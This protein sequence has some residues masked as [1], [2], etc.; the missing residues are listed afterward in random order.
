MQFRMPESPASPTPYEVLGVSASASQDEL[1]RAYR[2]LLRA[3]HPDTGGSAVRFT[4]VQLA[5]ERVGDPRD[6]QA[7]DRGRVGG[8]SESAGGFVWSAPPAGSSRRPEGSS[9]RARSYGHPGGQARERFLALMREWVGRGVRLAD[10]YE[11]ALVRSAPRE[12]RQWLAK[13]LAEEETA[14]EVSALGIGHTLW[15]DVAVGRGQDKIDHLVL[16]PAGLFAVQAEDWGGE[17]RVVRG[18]V[19]GDAVDPAEEPVRTL[20][21]RTRALG[22]TLAVRFTAA[23]IAVPDDALAEPR[24]P[25]ARSRRPSM[26]VLRRSVLPQVLRDGISEG[27]RVGVGEVFEV[28]TRLQAGIRFV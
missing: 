3:T 16:G 6:R 13:A 5:W 10:P 26:V 8:A 17:V 9:L 1:R 22:R 7:Y 2:R 27:S 18:E 19:V 25:V 21:R 20:V 15:S 14:R 4:A 28:R 23:V 24:I 11:P 12:I